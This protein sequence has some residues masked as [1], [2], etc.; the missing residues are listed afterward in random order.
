MKGTIVAL[1]KSGEYNGQKWYQISVQEIGKKYATKGITNDDPTC[2]LGK[3]DELEIEHTQKPSDKPNTYKPGTFIMNHSFILPNHVLTPG[4]KP[5]QQNPYA[6]PPQTANLVEEAKTYAQKLM[7]AHE[8]LYHNV[9]A[10]LPPE[11]S[12]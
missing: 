8:E 9:K 3:N 11:E 4:S 5:A 10:G 1:H 6:L 12:V 7:K 2:Y